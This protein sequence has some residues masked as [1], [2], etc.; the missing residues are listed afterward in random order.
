MWP[1]E[2]GFPCSAKHLWDSPKYELTLHSF[3]LLSSIPLWKYTTICLSTHL[4]RDIWFVFSFW[5]SQ[6]RLLWTSIKQ[7]FIWTCFQFSRASTQSGTGQSLG[8]CMF[9]FIRIGQIISQSYYTILQQSTH[10][11][12]MY[13]SSSCFESDNSWQYNR[14]SVNRQSATQC[15]SDKGWL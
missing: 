3:L 8:K 10:H 14:K 11:Q 5:L 9:T 6:I 15:Y 12:A 1:F 4:L 13:E 2:I 7:G